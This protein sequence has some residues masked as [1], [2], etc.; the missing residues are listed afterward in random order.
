MRRQVVV[1]GIGGSSSMLLL[2]RD[3][4]NWVQDGVHLLFSIVSQEG[5]SKSVKHVQDP[6]RAQFGTHDQPASTGNVVDLACTFS[7]KRP[8]PADCRPGAGTAD[9]V[10]LISPSPLRDR[11]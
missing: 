1:A 5:P 10:S 9:L 6:V 7:V 8:Q 3:L 11:T 2:V 4:V